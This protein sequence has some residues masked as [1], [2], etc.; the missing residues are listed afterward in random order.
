MDAT[1]IAEGIWDSIKGMPASLYM[2]VKRTYISTGA[3][4]YERQL[5]NEREDV[6]FYT[7][8]KALIR[9]E[10]PLRRLITIV[11]TEFTTSL[12]SMVNRQFIT[13]SVTVPVG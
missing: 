4:G 12:M 3:L 6:R 13:R 5:R 9:N 8:I 7:V 2:G 1:K 10:E 11:I